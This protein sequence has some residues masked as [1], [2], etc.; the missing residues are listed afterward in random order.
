M[1]LI[2]FIFLTLCLES[3]VILR[4]IIPG[5]SRYDKGDIVKHLDGI[6]C[7]SAEFTLLSY[8][9]DDGTVDKNGN[10]WNKATIFSEFVPDEFI[11]SRSQVLGA[12]I[13][14]LSLDGKTD[15]TEKLE[16]GSQLC[17]VL[18]HI[19]LEAISKILF[20]RPNLTYDDVMEALEPGNIVVK[21][22]FQCGLTPNLMF[23]FIPICISL[24]GAAT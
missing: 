13:D 4:G 23:L 2:L 17:M 22:H 20:A 6:L 1:D 15:A 19:P 18:R 3:T 10:P 9:L 5:D 14:G 11:Q 24:W 16:E 12:L 7:K 21:R 8:K